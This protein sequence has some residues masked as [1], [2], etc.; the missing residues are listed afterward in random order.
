MVIG[1]CL[2]L[3]LGLGLLF[4]TPGAGTLIGLGVGLLLSALLGQR[5]PWGWMGNRGRD[6]P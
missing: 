1:G 2:I 4:G 3:G 5:D 6:K